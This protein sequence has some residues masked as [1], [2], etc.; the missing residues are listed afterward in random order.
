MARL[1]DLLNEETLKKINEN[2]LGEMPSSK[3]M[4]MKWNPITA[5]SFRV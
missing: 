5:R 3:L 4:K 1:K 2:I